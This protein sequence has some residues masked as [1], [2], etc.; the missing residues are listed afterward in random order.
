MLTSKQRSALK[1]TAHK[2]DAI[3]QLGKN[4]ITPELTQAIDDALE[5]RELIKVSVLENCANAPSEA[6]EILSERT[7]SEVVQVIGR[8]IILFRQSKKAS[9]ILK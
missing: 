8:K 1:A 9:K 2:L 4:G 7:R 6:A 3:F 5:A